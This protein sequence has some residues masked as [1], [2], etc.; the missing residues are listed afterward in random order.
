MLAGLD[1]VEPGLVTLTE[2]HPESEMTSLAIR[3]A[4]NYV[5]AAVGRVPG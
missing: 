5:W 2:W 4:T 1:L 3:T